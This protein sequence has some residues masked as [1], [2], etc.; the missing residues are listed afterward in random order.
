MFRNKV[1][2]VTGSSLGI[3]SAIIKELA[4]KN[5]DVVINYNNS[6]KEANELEQ[7]IKENYNVKCISIKCD[8][9]NE[10]EVEKMIENIIKEF[11]K[12]DIL[13]NNA[14]IEMN[15]DFE[16]KNKETFRKVL[17]I[18]LIGSFLVSKYVGKNMLIN[19]YGKIIN[20]TSNNAINKNDPSTLEYD[21]SKAGLISLTH[22]LARQYAPYINVN[23]IAPGWVLTDKVKDLDLSLDG[24]LQLEERKKILLNRF[25]NPE[26]IASLVSFLASDNASYIN[27][28]VIRI[29]G[30]SY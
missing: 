21:A 5:C 29:D 24:M 30:G 4:S 14:A 15:S 20:I 19:K 8:I 6:I 16:Q 9:S 26:E 1:A 23:A 18:N 13:V 27:D 17:D 7:Y 28:E 12:I 25:A 22:N 10:E 3:G 11:G 2:L